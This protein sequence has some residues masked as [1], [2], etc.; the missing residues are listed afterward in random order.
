MDTIAR[1]LGLDFKIE[2]TDRR[3]FEFGGSNAFVTL[4]LWYKTTTNE[5]SFIKVQVNFIERLSYP[6]K[7]MV[8]NFLLDKEKKDVMAIMPEY[9]YLLEPI[10]IK[11]YD[12]KEILLE[13][14]RAIMTRRG[15]KARDF[16]DVF[17]ITSKEK[18][19]LEGYKDKIINKVKP[20]LKFEKYANNLS[21]K[22][23]QFKEQVIL[24]AEEKLLIGEIPEGFDSFLKDFKVFLEELLRELNS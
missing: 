4:K 13:K 23:L 7:E 20:M 10:K 2:K 11:V 12:I 24:K 1:K 18:L 16:L 17:I 8:A 14:I 15:V 22:E 3:Y 19:N 9:S 21:N 5:L 6:V